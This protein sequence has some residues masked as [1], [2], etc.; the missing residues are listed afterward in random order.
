MMKK[1]IIFYLLSWSWGLPMTLCGAL[2]IGILRLCGHRLHRFGACRYMEI[3]ENWGGVELGMFFLKDKTPSAHICLHEA[4]HSVQNILFG[5]LMP[6]LV[7][8][9]SAVRYHIRRIAV[10]RGHSPRR[11]YE[12]IWFERQATAWG[13]KF[14]G[15]S[16]EI[17]EQSSP[18]PV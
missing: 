3:G 2:I 12:A 9:P 15:D 17:R 14:F 4:G 5:P 16:E 7:S 13:M 11:H 1:R 18:H 6:F 10:R 8:I